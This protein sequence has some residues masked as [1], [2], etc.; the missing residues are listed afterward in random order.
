M[1][2]SFPHFP[3]AEFD[4][5]Q[6]KLVAED[7]R[8]DLDIA[9][10]GL[11]DGTRLPKALLHTDVREYTFFLAIDQCYGVYQ[12]TRCLTCIRNGCEYLWLLLLAVS[13]RQPY[14][15]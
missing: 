1:H 6:I 10:Y 4:N 9:H 12:I 3:Q 15:Q 13:D 11:T 2:Q 5:E 8:T 14:R 7:R